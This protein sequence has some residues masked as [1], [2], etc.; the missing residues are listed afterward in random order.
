MSAVTID[1]TVTVDADALT[2]ALA[3][4][5]LAFLGDDEPERPTPEPEPEADPES[6]PKPDD[7]PDP[8]EGI[9]VGDHL[10]CVKAGG[11][12]AT[13][14]A[15]ATTSIAARSRRSR[16]SMSPSGRRG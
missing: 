5:A 7:E 8:L 16:S 15:A 11:S 10:R 14:A 12:S 6:D 2:G 1:L 4:V 9:R 3:A 13:T